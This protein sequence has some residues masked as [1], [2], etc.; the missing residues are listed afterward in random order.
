VKLQDRLPDSV[1]I[2][3]K[4]YAADFD[5]R[6]VLRMMDILG[7]KNLTDEAREWLAVK[8]VMK[9]PVKGALD[10]IR[11]IL[12]G[13]DKE[14]EQGEDDGTRL[15]SFDQDAAL[16]R[17]AFWQ[18]Y[19]INLYTEKLHWLAFLELLRGLPE[20]T[21]YME[22]VGIRAKPMPAPTKYNMEERQWLQK[23]KARYAVKQT[24]EETARN[25][26]RGVQKVFA[27]LMG[28]IKG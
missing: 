16:I 6:N 17:A 5:F 1:R 22:V 2:N 19:R 18:T 14:E 25:Y 15:T 26:D 9:K 7:D 3:G 4:R 24:E 10:A 27:G 23:A 13:A 8:C 11:K 20:G 21:R 12:F 28:M